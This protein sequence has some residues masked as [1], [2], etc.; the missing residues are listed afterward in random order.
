MIAT[1]EGR[2]AEAGVLEIV[3]DVGGVGYSLQVPVTTTEKLPPVGEKV[4][5]FT[6]QVIREDAHLLYGFATRNERE[7]FRLL[8]EQVTG[9]G[10]KSALSI[11]SK[12]SLP[13]LQQAI[14]AGDVAM[15]SKCPGI[16]RKTAER[17]VVELKDKLGGALT[18]MPTATTGAGVVASLPGSAL[19]D[20]VGALMALGYK[21][22]E[23][24][25]AIRKASAALG[26][27][28]TTE[29]LLKKA[30]KG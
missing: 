16:G 3:L 8:I 5:L 15:L 22:I 28:A 12:L 26:A 19:Q 10:P 9:I 7:F 25:Q 29:D 2:L 24:D 11:M 17:I 1:L 27:G 23:A 21:P 30:L 14:S 4:K 18:T 13:V 6:H 20:A